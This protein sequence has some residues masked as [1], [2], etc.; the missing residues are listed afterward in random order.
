MPVEVEYTA[1]GTG[2]VHQLRQG[3]QRRMLITVET[4]ASVGQL[5]IVCDEIDQVSLGAITPRSATSQPALDS[6]QE[7]DLSLLRERW[8]E[9]L[10]RRREYLDSH[11]Q[12]L[13]KKQD[14]NPEDAEREKSLVAQWLTLTEE[15]NAV[16][17]PAPDSGVPGAP[18]NSDF[19]PEQGL[20]RHMPI[21][22]LD[23]PG[24]RLHFLI[25]HLG[26]YT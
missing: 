24:E 7:E 26:I 25:V 21:I 10:K 16:L 9:A 17:V 13:Q 2:G 22:F 18:T 19:K 1:K 14:K 5:P 4:S 15:R 11:L 20:E 8:G 3:L 12:E 6:Y 23:I